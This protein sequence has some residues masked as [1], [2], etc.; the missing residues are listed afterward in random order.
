MDIS[1]A[2]QRIM[3]VLAQ[4][5]CLRAEKDNN[6]KIIDIECITRDGWYLTGMTILLFRKLKHKG[7]IKSRNGGPYR[8]TRLGLVRVRSQADNR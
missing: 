7:L 2:E 4:G 5:G 3:H 1:K 6:G 8:A